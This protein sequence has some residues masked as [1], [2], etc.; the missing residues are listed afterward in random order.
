MN[1][2]ELLKKQSQSTSKTLFSRRSIV[3]QVLCNFF[4]LPQKGKP[5]PFLVRGCTL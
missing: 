1:L 3:N 4:W 5:L 2:A